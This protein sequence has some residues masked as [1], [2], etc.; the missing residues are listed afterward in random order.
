M[1]KTANAKENLIEY[2][3]DAYLLEQEVNAFRAS[4][5]QKISKDNPVVASYLKD[6]LLE[7]SGHIA[8]LQECL[9]RLGVNPPQQNNQDAL[10]PAT[11]TAIKL[12]SDSVTGD[13]MVNSTFERFEI[14]LYQKI[15]DLAEKAGEP[16]TASVCGSILRQEEAVADWLDKTTPPLK[17][18]SQDEAQA[19]GTLVD[20]RLMQLR[21]PETMPPEEAA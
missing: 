11:Q 14:A 10:P 9:L 19:Q 17:D 15:V 8:K 3:S 1:M 18:A 7:R 6:H 13:A 16:E 20:A 4:R 2:L 21:H 12:V 5:I